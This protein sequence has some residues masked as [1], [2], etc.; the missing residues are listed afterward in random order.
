MKVAVL[1]ATGPSGQAVVEEAL[2]RGHE[3]L[4]LVRNPDGMT[5]THEKLQ[6]QKID[7][8]DEETV[9]PHMKG[10]DAVVSC[11]GSKASFF[12]G[13]TLYSDTIKVIAS[14]MRKANVN[15]FVCMSAWGTKYTQYE[16]WF[17][18][19]LLRPLF[20]RTVLADMSRMEDYI[21]AECQD[22][23]YT[24]VRPPGLT[25]N[26]S[27]GKEI[28]TSDGQF[29]PNTKGSIPRKDVAKFIL[30]CLETHDWDRKM[31]AITV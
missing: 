27:T 24:V 12:S 11:I 19:Y 23:N 30:Q 17:M 26:E 7:L 10:C 1:G 14:S 4:A 20:L 6:V 3:V 29:V 28:K 13:I 16:P 5:V 25:L 15:R 22:I 8:A 31:V 2:S 9:I 18:T 21:Q